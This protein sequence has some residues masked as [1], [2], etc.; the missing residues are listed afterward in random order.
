[1]KTKDPVLSYQSVHSGPD[2]WGEGK[3]SLT[4]LLRSHCFKG[5]GILASL[6]DTKISI[7]VQ[8]GEW[9]S[10]VLL[11]SSHEAASLQSMF[12]GIGI[13][14]LW[15]D[16]SVKEK[17]RDCCYYIK[18]VSIDLIFTEWVFIL[19]HSTRWMSCMAHCM[20]LT[21]RWQRMRGCCQSTA[22]SHTP[23]AERWIL[24]VCWVFVCACTYVSKWYRTIYCK[25]TQ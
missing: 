15:E 19:L 16:W 24:W 22:M 1:M 23:R 6:P 25:Y 13:R 18:E 14:I 20:T 7:W 8:D 9:N 12:S 10:A 5:G 17:T 4:C 3:V 2:I 21:A 11:T